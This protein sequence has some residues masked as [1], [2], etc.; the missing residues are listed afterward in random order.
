MANLNGDVQ[1]FIVQRLACYD[2]PKAIVEAVAETFGVSVD[3]RQ[4]EKYNPERGGAK[5][6]PKWCTLFAETRKKFLEDLETIPIANAAVRLRS[7][8]RMAQRAEDKGNFPLA[9]ALHEQ[10][11]KER[12]G[13]YTNRRVLD[14]AD[15]AAALAATLGVSADEISA[16][17]AGL[18]ES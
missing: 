9:A 2:T 6:A 10:A 11:A 8:N 12:G 16:A 18:S 13:M 14:P 3:R 15:P 4:V 1:A 7:L 5:P 17:V